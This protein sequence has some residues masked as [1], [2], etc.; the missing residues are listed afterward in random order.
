MPYSTVHTRLAAEDAKGSVPI[1]QDA[2]K[3]QTATREEI[4]AL[5]YCVSFS[6]TQPR[7]SR[8]TIFRNE[9]RYRESAWSMHFGD[10]ARGE[11]PGQRNIVQGTRTGSS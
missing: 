10:L 5:R 9:S 3:I 1:S 4:I 7:L 6:K 11:T 8:A 2:N